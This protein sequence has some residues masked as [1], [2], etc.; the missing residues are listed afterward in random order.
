MSYDNEIVLE[1]NENYDASKLN[2][3]DFCK[4]TDIKEGIEKSSR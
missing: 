4:G 1:R 3:W 2:C